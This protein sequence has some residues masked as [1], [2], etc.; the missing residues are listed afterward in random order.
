MTYAYIRPKGTRLG[1]LDDPVCGDEKCLLW[2]YGGWVDD[3]GTI[4]YN[5]ARQE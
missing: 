1:E 2:H 4:C 3:T 5:Y